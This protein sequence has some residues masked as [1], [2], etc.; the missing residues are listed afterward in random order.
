MEAEADTLAAQT[1][2]TRPVKAFLQ[3]VLP[4]IQGQNW[5]AIRRLEAL[6]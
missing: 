3:K 2:G 1:L 4:L 6:Q 5:D